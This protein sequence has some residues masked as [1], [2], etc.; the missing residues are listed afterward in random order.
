VLVDN[1]Q[2]LLVMFGL[3]KLGQDN[4]LF[5]FQASKFETFCSKFT[6]EYA[7]ETVSRQLLEANYY[8]EANCTMDNNKFRGN[9]CEANYY[10]E[11]I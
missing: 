9:F 6:I 2:S 1:L 4:K 10:L 11:A 3:Q 8:L 5:S 7:C